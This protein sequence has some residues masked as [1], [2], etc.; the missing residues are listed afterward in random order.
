MNSVFLLA[1]QVARWPFLAHS[2]FP[3]LVAQVKKFLLTNTL[4]GL[5]E[6]FKDPVKK[7]ISH[8]KA[9]LTSHLVNNT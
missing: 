6:M 8:H 1:T 3:E 9:I 5:L 7:E 4:A 2:G